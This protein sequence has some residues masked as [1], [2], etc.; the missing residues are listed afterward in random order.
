MIKLVAFDWNGTLL[1]DAKASHDV[2]NII[3]SSYGFKNFSFRHYQNTF[4]IP[5]VDFYTANGFKRKEFIKNAEII[6]ELFVN[7]YEPLA[8]RCRTRSG[9]REV[10]R[11]LKKRKIQPIIF[12]NHIRKNIERQLRRLK[13]D[14]HLVKVLAREEKDNSHLH[15]RNKE[16][17]L[18]QYVK[19]HKLKPKEVMTV[20]DT[21]EETEIGKKHGF[22]TAAITGG[23]ST[24]ARLKKHNPDFLIHNLQELVGIIKKLNKEK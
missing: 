5:I 8:D 18:C 7:N 14:G 2:T 11:E 3:F 16:V 6:Q 9:T 17:M 21:P 12:S 4:D 22:I 13:V 24:V 1:A 19:E 23:Y 10:L 20:G 15:S